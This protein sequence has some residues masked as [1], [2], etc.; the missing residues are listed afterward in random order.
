MQ[1]LISR[2]LL[3]SRWKFHHAR[4]KRA[5][6]LSGLLGAFAAAVI[7][8][9]SANGQTSS[10][11]VAKSQQAAVK[12]YPDLGKAETPLNKK[13]LELYQKAKAA[14]DPL[15]QNPDWPMLLAKQAASEISAAAEPKA[16]NGET[17]RVG[18]IT[19]TPTRLSFPDPAGDPNDEEYQK[20]H[21]HHL[22]LP[23][24]VFSPEESVVA[25]DKPL[26]PGPD[27]WRTLLL[28]QKVCREGDMD[29][30]V[31]LYGPSSQELLQKAKASTPNAA[32]TFAQRKQET[33]PQELLMVL[34]VESTPVAIIRFAA[35][36]LHWMPFE[37]SN[38]E[39]LMMESDVVKFSADTKT[40]L[41]DMCFQ[42]I[43][44]KAETLIDRQ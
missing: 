29:G 37:L 34:Q 10:A 36:G 27:I 30:Y 21:G 19:L 39:Y 2:R 26:P 7:S 8:P 18:T 13:F 12:L 25:A 35:G 41:G 40:M 28:L 44:K 42:L 43:G 38:G 9:V 22:V 15:L 16:S 33:F 4:M 20:K 3:L 32:E 5:F 14:G 17:T 6:V 24:R 11:D 23:A 1:W 31:K